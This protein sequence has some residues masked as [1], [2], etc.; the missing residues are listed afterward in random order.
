MGHYA[1]RTRLVAT[2]LSLWLGTAGTTLVQAQGTREIPWGEQRGAGELTEPGASRL[3][4]AVDSDRP[5]TR[6]AAAE[7]RT[8]PPT[9]PPRTSG[10][11]PDLWWKEDAGETVVNPEQSVAARGISPRGEIIQSTE[12]LSWVGSEPI[13]AGDLLGRIN[14][15][16]QPAVGKV[17]EEKLDEQRWLL[18]EQLLPSV[19]E[20]KMVYLDF[21]RRLE[22]EQ[23]KAIRESVYKQFDETQL[24]RLVEQAKLQ[25]PAELEAR[26]RSLGT[27]VDNVRRSFYEQVA[28]REMIRRSTTDEEE[29]THDQLLDYY[30][31]HLDQYE[32]KAKS[33]WEHLMTRFSNF[34]SKRDAYKAIAE[35]GNAVLRG[36]KFEQVARRDSQG[37]TSTDG[38]LFDWTTQ[39]S[40]VSEMLDDAIF[41]LP[42]G[43]MS[44]ILE[45]EDGFHIVRVIERKPAGRVPFLEAQVEI[46]DKIKE[47]RRDAKAKQYLERLKRETYVWNRFSEESAT[48]DRGRDL[49]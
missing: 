49:K 4:P 29:V 35:M 9:G 15:L 25:G 39:G 6:V 23:V 13:L 46:R 10:N 38:G 44:D 41:A 2:A 47:E 34:D 21:T 28:A 27:S 33:R 26:L 20:S 16:L 11:E 7:R 45:D 1:Y 3:L 18:M 32:F 30:Q 24:P 8:S 37:P 43:V 36:A 17:P 14:E 40:L 19:I 48:A 22:A 5:P 12:I 42:V 31:D